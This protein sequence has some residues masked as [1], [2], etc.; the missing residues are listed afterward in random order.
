MFA[1]N[2]FSLNLSE[3]P[4]QQVSRLNSSGFAESRL[5]TC[6]IDDELIPVSLLTSGLP[7]LSSW[8][9]VIHATHFE[10]ASSDHWS[11]IECPGRRST[12]RTL[13]CPK[14]MPLGC[15]KRPPLQ[16]PSMRGPSPYP[17]FW[18]YIQVDHTQSEVFFIV[19]GASQVLSV[20]LFFSL[21]KGQT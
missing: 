3:P 7:L 2:V 4:S 12:L 8:S 15:K 13:P 20:R 14:H 19:F 1:F 5:C 21:A 6:R 18:T 16:C 17:S 10:Q 11:F 9:V